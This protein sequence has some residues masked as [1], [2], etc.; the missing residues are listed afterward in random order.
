MQSYANSDTNAR[1]GIRRAM[2]FVAMV[3]LMAALVWPATA[4]PQSTA[5]GV[6]V[7]RLYGADV[8]VKNAVS[9]ES[10]YGMSTA[11]LASGS[12]ITVRS[13]RAQIDLMHGGAI[14]ICGPAHFTLLESGGAITVALEYGRVRPQVE[15]QVNLTVYTPL[16]VSTPVAIGTNP[17][18]LTVGLDQA[19]AMCTLTSRGA[20]RIEQQFT[21]QSVLVP[22]GGEI[23][24]NGGQLGTMQSANGS[25]DCE[26]LVTRNQAPKSLELSRP[27]ANPATRP[28]PATAPPPP[29]RVEQPIYRVYL[30]PLSFDAKAPDESPDPDPAHILMVREV[31]PLAD[32]NFTARA[33]PAA[34][35]ARDYH[36]PVSVAPIVVP[37][38]AATVAPQQKR[39]NILARF[40]GAVF[41]RKGTRCVGAGCS[42]SGN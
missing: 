9:M 32:P 15:A 11:L 42:D 17:R 5:A 33:E 10:T 26:L 28:L 39:P 2:G 36:P 34:E 19:G 37:V 24:L 6:V 25:C 41:R 14:A 1:D 12:E 18:D 22:Q 8:I 3:S 40:F 21:G 30:P 35:G 31:Q 4:G 7:G 29:P 23:T 38:K 27:L 20:V 16:I 13:G